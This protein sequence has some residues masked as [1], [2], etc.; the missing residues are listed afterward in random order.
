[1]W[2]LDNAVRG[3]R[4]NRR[5]EGEVEARGDEGSL[6]AE[7]APAAAG[8][9]EDVVA[10]LAGAFLLFLYLPEGPLRGLLVGDGS[11]HFCH[12]SAACAL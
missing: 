10:I 7:V 4:N 12:L 3:A 1:M 9:G 11:L 8:F 5:G 2:A 6:R